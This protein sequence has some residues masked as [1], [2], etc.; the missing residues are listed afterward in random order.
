M[1]FIDVTQIQNIVKK[2]IGVWQKTSKTFTF[3]RDPEFEISVTDEIAEWFKENNILYDLYEIS[4]KF[5]LFESNGIII[6]LQKTI[7][8]FNSIDYAIQFKLAWCNS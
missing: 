7:I 1:Y 5:E 2:R 8:V 6:K 3:V 4:N